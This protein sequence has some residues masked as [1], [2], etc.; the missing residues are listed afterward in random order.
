MNI[1]ESLYEDQFEDLA[2]REGVELQK[3]YE[4]GYSKLVTFMP[5]ADYNNDLRVKSYHIDIPYKNQLISIRYEVGDAQ[6]AHFNCNFQNGLNPGAFAIG[7][8][9]HFI[10]LLFN[11]KNILKVYSEDNTFKAQIESAL[12]KCGLEEIARKSLFAP[13]I[14]GGENDSYHLTAKYS[15]SFENKKEVL[16][17]MIDFFKN[18][19]DSASEKLRSPGV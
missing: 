7:H 10:R 19:I 3:E 18:I 1:R 13:E 12:H 8:R 2:S 14:R 5:M 4:S 11:K 17:P 6:L 9:N 16:K 15:L